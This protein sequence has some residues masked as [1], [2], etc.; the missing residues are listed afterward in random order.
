LVGQNL[1]F[2]WHFINHATSLHIFSSP[3][4]FNQLR[5]QNIFQPLFPTYPQLFHTVDNSPRTQAQK[6]QKACIR[7]SPLVNPSAMAKYKNP[8][9]L[10][11]TQLNEGSFTHH[12]GWYLVE[13]SFDTLPVN[14][15]LWEVYF[16]TK[17][18]A[19]AFVLACRK[20]NM[21]T[22]F[23]PNTTMRLVFGP[24]AVELQK[25]A[26]VRAKLRKAI[27]EARAAGQSAPEPR[28]AAVQESNP[29]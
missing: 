13:V 5:P 4:D 3:N 12:K 10:K 26:K 2:F 21:R 16:K 27:R 28:A 18:Q 23:H 20:K 9:I 7:K 8:Y 19:R 24:R 29:V 22:I 14:C 25:D 11:H 17:P 1:N 6:P 15:T